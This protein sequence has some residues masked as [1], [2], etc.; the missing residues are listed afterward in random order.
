MN[1]TKELRMQAVE[2]F[3]EC[4]WSNREADDSFSDLTD[5]QVIAAL[6]R[7]YDGGF[8]QFVRDGQ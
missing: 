5:D 8:A 4:S 7:H 1:M 2:W 6:N 3:Q